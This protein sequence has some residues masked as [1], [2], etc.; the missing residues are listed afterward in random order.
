M[1]RRTR[2]A[3]S[4]RGGELCERELQPSVAYCRKTPNRATMSCRM[5]YGTIEKRIHIDASPEVVYEVVSRPEH[6]VCW[7]SDAA[8]FEPAPGASG[9][10]AW[11]EKAHTR[12]FAVNITVVE[13]VPSRRFS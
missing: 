7:W 8:D 4:S 10:I 2:P 9:V 11:T 13:A 6:I 12:P 1:P 3:A 5:E